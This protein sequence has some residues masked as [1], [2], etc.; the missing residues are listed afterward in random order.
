MSAYDV[1]ADWLSPGK[2]PEQFRNQPKFLSL[3]NALANELQAVSVMQEDLKTLT[4][5]KACVGAQLDGF[6]EIVVLRR[7]N[8]SEY[9]EG[10][11]PAIFTDDYYKL[12]LIYKNILNNTKGT[13]K[14]ITKSLRLMFNPQKIYY[15][16]TLA[17]PA[18]LSIVLSG[19]FNPVQI[20]LIQNANVVPAVDGVM[21]Q[22]S[23]TGTVF[24]GFGDLNPNAVGFGKGPFA[25]SVL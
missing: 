22:L 17:A 1:L 5:L 13:Y 23:Y 11:N 9:Y 12:F 15:S 20:D 19:E 21:V 10:S 14:D 7:V 18:T 25:H 24:F 2:I 3:I 16:Q 4:D 8:M 6:G